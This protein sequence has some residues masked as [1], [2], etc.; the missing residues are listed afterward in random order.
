MNLRQQVLALI[1]GAGLFLVILDLV[2]RRRLDERSSCLW[3][4]TGL[5]ILVLAVWYDL[6]LSFST[7]IGITLP[8]STVFF[9]GVMFLM[10]VSLQQATK[11]SKLADQVKNLT[12][13]I[14]IMDSYIEDLTQGREVRGEGSTDSESRQGKVEDTYTETPGGDWD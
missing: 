10:A 7:L 11:I 1:I 8:T 3:L 4:L 9:F 6:L 14:A 13:K 2:R 5:G 12:Q